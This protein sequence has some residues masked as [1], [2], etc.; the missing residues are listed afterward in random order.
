MKVNPL[1]QSSIVSRYM[2]GASVVPHKTES[3]KAVSEND[4]VEFSSG[5]QGYA[6]LLRGARAALD[7][8]EQSEDERVNT[9]KQKIA[10][11]TYEISD[12]SLVDALTGKRLV[13]YG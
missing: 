6:Q 12:S 3:V 8:A 1:F 11:G 13:E 2:S 10:A 4:T 7:K 9:L 5:A